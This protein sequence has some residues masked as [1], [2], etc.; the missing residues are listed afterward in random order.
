MQD[1]N[2]KR[3]FSFPRMVEDL[4]RAFLPAEALA[5]LDFSSLD[6]L[7][8]EYVSDELLQRH[9]DCVW[10]LRRRGRWLYLLVLLEFQ[11][12]D[13]P[14]MALRILTYTSLLYQELVRN[15]ALDAR[16]RLPAVL[17]VVLYNG[18]ARWRAAV[19]VGEL[20][21][22]VGPEL[23]PYQPSQRYLVV[24]ERHVGAE[25]L[26][27]RNLMG[28]VLGLEQSRG[29]ADLVRVV[30]RLVEWLRDSGDGELKRAFTDW[31]WRLAGHF[32]PGDAEPASVRTLEGARMTLEERVAEWPKQWFREGR[33]QGVREGVEQVVRQLERADAE[34]PPGDAP[35]GVGMT[36]EERVAEW[37]KQ[38]LQ[39]GREQGIREVVERLE[40]A[41][42]EPPPGDAP[43]G[44]GMTLEERVAEWPKQWFREG[45]EQGAREGIEQ[46]VR[47]LE[48]ADAEP[49]PG[50]APE[51]VGMTLEERV[52]E[53]PKQWLQEGR[54]QGIREGR[55]QGAREGIEQ[56]L[57]HERALLRRQVAA[58]RF[59]AQTAERLSG[60]LAGIADPEGLAEV[61]EWLV[62]C[63]TGSEFLARVDPAPDG[64]N[65]RSSRGNSHED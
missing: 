61:G 34:P 2:Y 41:D 60:V 62:R 48:R 21:A 36:L 47:Q 22:P 54:E 25:D 8:A 17:P 6:K 13:E 44:V 35:E 16:E 15:G 52:A 3:L 9:G 12:T 46:V 40:R 18:A 19:E 42:A 23:A 49:P 4:L 58:S 1:P 55:E 27:G 20:I 50:D 10:R 59:G 65:R 24:D 56:G 45:R 33:E 29:P 37:P 53:W 11:S 43:E 32:E 57:E 39:E 7:P 30:G 31:V 38:W 28:A 26:P 64:A 63:G 51:G 14:R 5:E